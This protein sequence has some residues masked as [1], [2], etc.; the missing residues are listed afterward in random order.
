MPPKAP[1]DYGPLRE[2]IASQPKVGPPPEIPE[3]T[4]ESRSRLKPIPLPDLLAKDYP[5]PD[6]A[7]E[8]L[9]ATAT[10]NLLTAAPNNWKSWLTLHA[11]LSLAK[12]SPLF[13]HFQTTPQGVL[14]V[15]EEDSERDLQRRFQMLAGE[16]AKDLPIHVAA[17][18][19]VK[20]DQSPWLHDLLETMKRLDLSFLILDSMSCIH[21]GVENDPRDMMRLFDSL[22]TFCK[23]GVTVLMT[24]HHRKRSR[25]P[26]AKEYA[27]EQTRGSSVIN[28]VPHGHLA[29]EET[30]SES[31]DRLI[32]CVQAKL[33]AAQKL[34]HP[35]LVK[36][37]ETETGGIQFEYGGEDDG[38][39][40]LMPK[41]MD[42]LAAHLKERRRWVSTAD[43]IG[44]KLAGER[45]TRQGL[46]QLVESGR[47]E[48]SSAERLKEAHGLPQEDE[49]VSPKM[50]YYR[51]NP[52]PA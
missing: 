44:A 7:I 20:L 17:G 23:E 40:T 9:V 28:A 2:W 42:E 47:V 46:K 25:L 41:L 19:E 24:H 51:A 3:P 27:Q 15:N 48:E 18:R 30:R 37:V 4:A 5:G 16:S 21:S 50:L 6:W 14:I 43:L 31:G 11:A 52:E 1:F 10:I 34:V 32:R 8:R 39:R 26:D 45:N 36:V 49:P 35:F 38:V 13:G 12:G 33:K 22:K 29:I